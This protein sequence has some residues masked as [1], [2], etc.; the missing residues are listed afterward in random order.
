MMLKIASRDLVK[1]RPVMLLEDHSVVSI[2]NNSSNGR[3]IPVKNIE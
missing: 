2:M 1:A 3:I